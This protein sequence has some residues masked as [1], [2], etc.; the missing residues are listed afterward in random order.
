MKRQRT[1][2]RWIAL[3]RRLPDDRPLV[4][5]EVGV[6]QGALAI[7]VL[8]ARPLVTHHMV[9]PWSRYDEVDA[10]GK[11]THLSKTM[12][13]PEDSDAIYQGVLSAVAQFGG[14]AVVHRMTSEEASKLF[15]D[16]S[17]DYVFIDAIHTYEACLA[18]IGFWAPKVKL[19][20][21]L[22][23][24]D[25]DNL[26]RFPGIRRAVEESFGKG[27]FVRDVDHTWWAL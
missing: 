12:R 13:T 24:H 14:R 10:L 5:V 9:D 6:Y 1:D 23:G 22:G 15:A 8:K 19:G 11:P 17:L 26:P 27:G 3:L 16:E 2:R 21:V 18:D 20:G 25:L 7:E 4:G